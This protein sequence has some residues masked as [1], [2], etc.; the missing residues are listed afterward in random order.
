MKK[1]T[2]KGIIEP[3]LPFLDDGHFETA[4]VGSFRVYWDW[5]PN[6]QVVMFPPVANCKL[7]LDKSFIG[8]LKVLSGTTVLPVQSM[9]HCRA[10][11]E[12]LLHVRDVGETKIDAVR[13]E[14]WPGKEVVG[15]KR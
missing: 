9:M 5:R 14:K 3:G 2:N 12:L 8:E 6:I 4:I 1:L 10:N 15:M 11:V 7:S 13:L